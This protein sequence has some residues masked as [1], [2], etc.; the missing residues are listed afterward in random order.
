MRVSTTSRNWMAFAGVIAILLIWQFAATIIKLP[1]ILPSPFAT[2]LQI[3]RLVV[4]P[5]FWNHLGATLQRGVTGF[6][7]SLF[8]G[9][10]IG[11]LAGKIDSFQAFLRPF[12]ILIRSTPVISVIILALIWFQRDT[13][14]VFVIFLMVFPIIFQ[15]VVEG[16]RRV[17]PE[18]LEMV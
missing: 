6:G 13:V 2:L 1:L 8:F 15:N 5:T 10:G 17:D 4:T 9:L 7:L 12:V 11:L 3:K 16:V 14:P 18:L